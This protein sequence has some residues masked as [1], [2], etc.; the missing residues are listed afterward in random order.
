MSKWKGF[1]DY[2]PLSYLEE[3]KLIVKEWNERKEKKNE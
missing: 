3:A 1:A 2:K